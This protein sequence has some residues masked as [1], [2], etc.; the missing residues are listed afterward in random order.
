M[1]D[2]WEGQKVEMVSNLFKGL[3]DKLVMFLFLFFYVGC[4]INSHGFVGRFP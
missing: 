3:D 4:I 1:I 2:V